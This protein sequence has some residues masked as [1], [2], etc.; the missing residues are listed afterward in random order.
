MAATPDALGRLFNVVYTA[1][2]VDIPLTDASA[3]TFISA[4]A[5]SG[6]QTMDFTQTDS[7]GVNS[8]IDLNVGTG[9]DA[10]SRGYVG[11]DTGG[12]WT[13]KAPSDA[14]SWAAGG[15]TN[16]VLVVTVRAEQLA[17]GYDR[18]QATVTGGTCVAI[19]HELKTQRRPSNLRSS[20]TA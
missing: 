16:D 20:L 12:T 5:G 6:D 18:V 3:V 2:G 15:T 17:D 7:T 10:E 9:A 11:P 4:D 8:E 13:E 14:N 1:S 19:L